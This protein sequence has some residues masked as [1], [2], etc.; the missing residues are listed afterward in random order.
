VCV[1]GGGEVKGTDN[2]RWERGRRRKKER[3]GGKESHA[4]SH[5]FTSLIPTV[6]THTYTHTHTH[7]AFFAASRAFTGVPSPLVVTE[8]SSTKL[9]MF[10]QS[11]PPW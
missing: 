6:Y 5:F 11:C 2:L 8:K 1:V 3:R 7:T 4:A 10:R 9:P